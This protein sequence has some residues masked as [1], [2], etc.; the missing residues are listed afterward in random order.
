M[1]I[2]LLLHPVVSLGNIN[3]ASNDRF[4]V[5]MFG[6]KLEKFLHAVHVSMVRDGKTWHAEFIGS[7]EQVLYRCL[8]IKNGVLRMYV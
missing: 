8:T 3:L 1:V 2:T 4:Y 6:G 5:R 7:V